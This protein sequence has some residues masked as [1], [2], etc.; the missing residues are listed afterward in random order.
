M[1]TDSQSRKNPF[2]EVFKV[3]ECWWGGGTSA[4]HHKSSHLKV[5]LG[6]LCTGPAAEGD[7]SHRRGGLPVLA[8]HLE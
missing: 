8:G 3:R 5:L 6:G 7:E 4:D 2:L 1:I